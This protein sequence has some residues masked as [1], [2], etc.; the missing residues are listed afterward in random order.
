MYIFNKHSQKSRELM[1]HFVTP[2]MVKKFAPV[3]IKEHKK[4]RFGWASDQVAKERANGNLCVLVSAGPDYLVPKMVR[5]IKF[6][7]VITS[8]MD[9]KRPWKYK[10]MCWGPNKVVALN[11]PKNKK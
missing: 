9:T 2:K 10:F 5:D 6:D 1:R 11:G 7:A 3:V 4:R 8:Q